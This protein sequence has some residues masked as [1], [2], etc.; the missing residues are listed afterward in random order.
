MASIDIKDAVIRL[1]E[2]YSLTEGLDTEQAQL[3]TTWA[4][5][6]LQQRAETAT[7]EEVFEQSF[8]DVTRILKM[9]NRYVNKRAE[10]DEV[11]KHRFVEL[12]IERAEQ[13][14]YPTKMSQADEFYQVIKD[15]ADDTSIIQAFLGFVETGSPTAT[16]NPEPP[17]RDV[18][19]ASLPETP[20]TGEVEPL[21]AE[22]VSEE[23][24]PSS[25]NAPSSSLKDSV[26]SSLDS[27]K[28]MAEQAP[29]IDDE[30]KADVIET[31]DTVEEIVAPSDD[32][33]TDTGDKANK[34]WGIFNI[35]QS[36]NKDDDNEKT[37]E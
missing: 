28:A 9:V 25:D 4:E 33:A 5:A 30:T 27:I 21:M 23:D 16:A 19:F 3:I 29:I 22:P 12:F 13:G 7:D 24:V 14:G 32:E 36:S 37:D 2:D 1:Y 35:F 8:V 31:I 20:E 10:M 15:I 17:I 26:R 6:Q 34:K 11:K 18:P